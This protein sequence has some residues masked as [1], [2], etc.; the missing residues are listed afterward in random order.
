MTITHGFLRTDASGRT[1]LSE[2]SPIVVRTGSIH[3][4]SELAAYDCIRIVVIRDGS[5]ILHGEFGREPVTVGH[6]V[7]L[8]DNVRC[9]TEPEGHVTSTVI[10][11]DPDYVADQIFWQYAHMLHD[12]LDAKELFAMLY[13]EAAQVLK[14][15]EERVGM[16]M[17]WLDEMAALS[18]EREVRDHFLRMQALW[19]SVA[20]AIVPYV[21]VSA[22]L[23]SAAQ[24]ARSRPSLPR[25]RKFRPIRNEALIVRAALQED[26]AMDWELSEMASMV[27]LSTRQFSRVFSAAFGKTP[28]TYLTMLRVEEMARILRETDVAIGAAGKK[29]GWQSRSRAFEAFREYTGVTPQQYRETL[30]YTT[31][32]MGRSDD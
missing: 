19:F 9:R 3:R 16:L 8:G 4:A 23:L 27:H 29:V 25:G 5:A 1:R 28:Q 21:R 15:G 30:G 22:P 31:A 11:I 10:C 18:T 24:R 20:D 14:I 13:A 12:R 7:V 6:V 17:P 2:Y 26:L 32:S